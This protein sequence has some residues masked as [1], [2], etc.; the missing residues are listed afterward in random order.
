MRKFHLANQ[1]EAKRLACYTAAEGS[2]TA[3]NMTHSPLLHQIHPVNYFKD[4]IPAIVPQQPSPTTAKKS[5]KLAYLFMVHEKN[6]FNQLTKTLEL[7]D[8]GDAIILIH[9]DARPQS[10]ELFSLIDSWITLRKK[11]NKDCAIH[12]AKKRFSNIWGHISLVFTQ[13]SGFWELFDMARW[14]FIFNVSNYDYPLKSNA[15][16]H[17]I[18]STGSLKNMNWIEYWTDTGTFFID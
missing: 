18:L 6:G 14:D 8:D 16:M 10:N 3:A 2:T 15:E 9:V 5:Y 1:Q 7:L 4:I 17:E 12:L 11:S 13:L